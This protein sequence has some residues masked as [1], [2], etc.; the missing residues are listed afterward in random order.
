MG[1]GKP[2]DI[3]RAREEAG[4]SEGGLSEGVPSIDGGGLGGTLLR[5]LE[6]GARLGELAVGT[7][8]GV[9]GEALLPRGIGVLGTPRIDIDWL[10][11]MEKTPEAFGAFYEQARQ[12]DWDAAIDEYQEALDAGKYYWG[13]SGVLGAFL[14]AGAPAA[15]GT[16]LMA[17]APKLAGTL[18]KLGAGARTVSGA[19]KGIIGTG[20]A[21]R[22]PWE[23]EE[24]IGRGLTW[25]IR[26]A[27]KKV[28]KV[29][30]GRAVDDI[31]TPDDEAPID[32][33]S[34]QAQRRLQRL[35][36][37]TVMAETF[38]RGPR[39][40]IV[41]LE[42]KLENAVEKVGRL[43][44]EVIQAQ[45]RVGLKTPR[46]RSEAERFLE[47]ADNQIATAKATVKNLERELAWAQTKG[48]GRFA[49]EAGAV[50]REET[51]RMDPEDLR[52]GPVGERLSS[53]PRIRTEDMLPHER[54]AAEADRLAAEATAGPTPP[55]RRRP[56]T[57]PAPGIP[58]GPTGATAAA[59]E[60]GGLGGRFIAPLRAFADVVKEV[61][62]T[63]NK[64]IQAAI[65]KTG[66]NPSV[67]KNTEVGRAVTA[68][69]RQNIAAEELATVAVSAALDTHAM[70]Y[71]GRMGHI[72]PINLDGTFGKTGKQWNDVFENPSNPAYN[73]NS[74]QRAYIDDYIRLM[75]EVE[76]MRVAAGL[77]PRARLREEGYF[78]VPRQVVSRDGVAVEGKSRPGFRR[79]YEEASEATASGIRYLNDPREVALIHI[80]SAY[81]EVLEK[82]LSDAIE[83]FALSQSAAKTAGREVAEPWERA[84]TQALNE[85]QAADEELLRVTN[86]GLEP[87]IR[88]ATDRVAKATKAY[89]ASV[90]DFNTHH[91]RAVKQ[92]QVPGKLFGENQPDTITL[93]QWKSNFFRQEDY[94]VLKKGLEIGEFAPR[95]PNIVARGFQSLA[96]MVRFLASVG[97]LAMPLT[98]GLPLLAR[99][100]VAWG[101][102]VLRH[103]Q[104]LFDPT[105]QARL[106]RDNLAEYQWLARNGVSVGDP[107]FFAA[108]APGQGISLNYAA[109]NLSK[110]IGAD[111][112]QSARNILRHAGKQTFGR[113]QS[114]YNAGLGYSRVQLLKGMR[115]KWK[116]TDAE[117]AQHIRN[118]TGAL[119]SRALGVGPSRRAI[120][121]MFLAFSPR[122]LRSTVSLIADA[123]RPWTPQ[124][125]AALR[126]LTSL[127]AGATTIYILAGLRLG[128]DW[129][130]I[131]EGLNPL[132]GRRFLSYNFNGDYIGVGG[133]VRSITQFLASMYSALAP[134]EWPGGREQKMSDLVAAN[135]YDN[136]LL[137]FH[138]TRGAP[139]INVAGATLEAFSS[140][141]V[142]PYDE[143]DGLPDLL[144]HIGTSSIPFALQGLLEGG[145][146]TTFGAEFRGARGGTIPKDR[147]SFELF[148]V[149]N[150]AL[151]PFMQ[152]IVEE[153]LEKDIAAGKFPETQIKNRYQADLEGIDAKWKDKQ[154]TIREKLVDGSIPESVAVNMYFDELNRARIKREHTGALHGIDEYEVDPDEKDPNILAL[155][156]YYDL[157]D[158]AIIGATEEREGVF[159]MDLFTHYRDAYLSED[160][161]ERREQKNPLT[162]E[163]I[164]HVYRNTNMRPVPIEIL[165]ILPDSTRNRILRSQEER[166]NFLKKYNQK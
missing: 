102:M 108:L 16:K 46:L 117:L 91:E 152:K 63:N 138:S 93:T 20:K 134:E 90:Q 36:Q 40:K 76:E 84:R 70:R 146:W 49:K 89:D 143:V 137:R 151:Q 7:L 64:L 37:E 66:I 165:R 62:T 39:A 106:I 23:V 50:L 159:S 52:W 94:D 47:T 123:T 3:S 58:D 95:E 153:K 139:G 136:P 122:L 77:P 116:G 101:K 166:R 160:P 149:E 128:R 28:Q 57:E 164:K 85:K 142:L 42:A 99:N 56:G 155:R 127:A 22:L 105:V 8:G 157:F 53:Y 132:N 12:G 156:G 163:Q 17:A 141:D 110:I 96:N 158:K 161:R 120:E 14:P 111:Y 29:R 67:A 154:E 6:R 38:S 74:S 15:V 113:F 97:D 145:R 65:A 86:A 109:R 148:G 69:Q 27:Y 147:K 131:Q 107:E 78:Y 18:G 150:E 48:R 44:K 81:K 19:E 4:L 43:E 144:K 126:A 124:G 83:P 21:L 11:D 112:V 33:I 75:D 140:L 51:A 119:D 82:Q 31:P 114:S 92:L 24:A 130:E 54:L 59:T 125:R 73:L 30:G 72:L 60:L 26:A 61:A 98:H 55:P 10:P 71:L 34:P 118:M 162:L 35:Q 25:P 87:Q 103:D 100:P 2:G 80:R 104:A 13:A 5:G 1:R 88:A 129:E 45:R 41:S 115:G 79:I 135:Q 121:G 68:F 133:Q 9:V 32:E